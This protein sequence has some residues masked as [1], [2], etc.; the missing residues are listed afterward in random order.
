MKDIEMTL[1]VR[2]KT[3]ETKEDTLTISGN[4]YDNLMNILKAQLATQ[5]GGIPEDIGK[6]NELSLRTTKNYGTVLTLIRAKYDG[7]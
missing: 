3:V 1:D 4:L 6:L 5:L 7:D 2:T